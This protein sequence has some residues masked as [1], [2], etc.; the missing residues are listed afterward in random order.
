MRPPFPMLTPDILAKIA[1]ASFRPPP[2]M[3]APSMGGM[4]M[5]QQGGTPGFN[6][7]GG[8]AALGGGLAGWKP[9]LQTPN[10]DPNDNRPKLTP[11]G[12]DPRLVDP[13]TGLPMPGRGLLGPI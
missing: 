4:P 3:G 11:A 7:A 5:P 2:L 6:I 10:G 9:S 13:L 12:L 8:L 1:E